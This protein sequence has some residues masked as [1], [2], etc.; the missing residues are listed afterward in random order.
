MARFHT[1]VTERSSFRDCRRRW[2]L[3][4]IERLAHK[5]RVAWALI[6]GT[7][8]HKALE[9]YYRGNKRSLAAAKRAF[10]KAWTEENDTLKEIYGTLYD[11]GIGDEWWDWR[12]KGLRILTYYK[13]FDDG[14]EFDF[15]EVIAV[16]I[17]ERAWV[18]ILDPQSEDRVEGLPLLSGAIDLVVRDKKKRIWIWDHKTT[19]SAYDARALDIDDQGTGYC[20]IYWRL[21]GEIPYGFVHNGLIKE[22]PVPPRLLKSGALSQD[23]AQR[24]TYDLYVD[25]IKEHGLDAS[26]YEDILAYLKDKGWSQFFVRDA[27]VFNE[28]QLWSFE[29]RLFYE[30]LD[31][32]KAINMP[33]RA[34][35]NP[36][37]RLCPMCA[38][39]PICQTMEEGG[40]PD[41]LKETMFD[42][43]E[44]RTEIPKKVLSEKWEGV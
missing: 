11:Q 40:E 22:P 42:I 16:N 35:P 25:A 21:T 20:Y 9:A 8:I 2:Y 1:T 10:N 41:Y 30:Y 13:Q 15:E 6:F 14:A 24:T 17:E 34:Y 32:Q 3:E 38:V 19:V 39:L 37:Q 26:E 7:C 43:V 5:N 18:D 28:E 27:V 4:T 29:Q 44:P 23:K 31:M 12:D 36:S 33:E